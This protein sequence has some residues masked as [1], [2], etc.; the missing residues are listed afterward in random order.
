MSQKVVMNF[1]KLLFKYKVAVS[2]C[3]LKKISF[4]MFVGIFQ[5]TQKSLHL[6]ICDAAEIQIKTYYFVNLVF[7]ID[8]S[9]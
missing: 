5:L 8:F 1:F 2:L 6:I 7:V 4:N 3:V 9:N